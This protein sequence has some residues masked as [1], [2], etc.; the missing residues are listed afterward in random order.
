MCMLSRYHKAH[1]VPNPQHTT[2]DQGI[3][4]MPHIP[5]VGSS[6]VEQTEFDVW[7]WSAQIQTSATRASTYNEPCEINI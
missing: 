4:Y 5:I 6:L 7:E 2:H 3:W 1:Y